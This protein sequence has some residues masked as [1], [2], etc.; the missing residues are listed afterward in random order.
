VNRHLEAV[1]RSKAAAISTF[2]RLVSSVEDADVKSAVTL[3]LAQAVFTPEETGL[4]D[5]SGDHVTLVE[6][7][8][9]PTVARSTGGSTP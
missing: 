5:G 4:V 8:V 7:A 9:L 3:T 1:A 2:Q 6:R